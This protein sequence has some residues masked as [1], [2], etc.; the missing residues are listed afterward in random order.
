MALFRL[1]IVWNDDS[2]NTLVYKYPFKNYGREV[3]DKSTLTVKESQVA[4]FVHKG[5]IADVFGPGLYNLG[6]EIFPILSKL[7]GWKYG[8]ETPITV[9]VYFINTKQFTNVKWGTM[10]PIMMRDPE[11]GFIRVRGFGAFAFRVYDPAVFLKELFGTNSSFKTEDITGYLKTML[12]SSLADVLGESRISA[13]DLAA[14]TL[15]FNEIVKAKIQDKFREIG[16]EMTNLFIE[17]MSVPQEV[18]KALDEKAKLGILRNDTDTLMKVSA[19]EAM[20]DAAKNTGAGGAFMGAGVGMGAGFGMGGIMAGA[21][22]SS[23]Q[24]N[25]QQK[26]EEQTKVCSVCGKSI[27]KNSKFCPE[28][29]AKQESNSFCP[30]CG[31]KVTGGAKFCSSCGKKL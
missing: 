14:N 11:F 12:L 17:N 22:N 26:V 9:D 28:C 18:E 4:I 8:F 21:F 16:L 6:T 3:N 27:A 25:T 13:V 5:Q 30:E 23:N 31:A 7:A 29:G 10:N 20:K 15:E 19:A 24:N 1:N 2:K